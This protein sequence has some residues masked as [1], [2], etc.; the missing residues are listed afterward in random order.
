MP[1]SFDDTMTGGFE[2]FPAASIEYVVLE[3]AEI[4]V[5]PRYYTRLAQGLLTIRLA[6]ERESTALSGPCFRVE[7]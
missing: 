7:G 4:P 3:D 1:D 6:A 5:M 2:A